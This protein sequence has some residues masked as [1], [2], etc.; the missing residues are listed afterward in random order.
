M[1]DLIKKTLLTGLG[2]TVTTKEKIESM[3][4][5]FVEKG[6]ISSQ[7]A[8]QMAER[9]VEDSKRE[10]EEAKGDV[11]GQFDSLLK[12]ANVVTQQQFSELEVR[13][14]QLEEQMERHKQEVHG[15][16][17]TSSPTG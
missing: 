13:V 14:K 10:Y 3:L 17:P 5:E 7:E 15:S 8:Q 9:I 2:A 16:D 11:Q 6:K 1:K 12:R 4:H